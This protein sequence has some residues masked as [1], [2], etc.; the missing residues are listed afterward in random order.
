VLHIL[1]VISLLSKPSPYQAININISK[2]NRIDLDNKKPTDNKLA[3]KEGKLT[4]STA[5]P[6]QAVILQYKIFI[7]N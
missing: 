7:C 2:L 3:M 6:I 1:L 5:A 4:V